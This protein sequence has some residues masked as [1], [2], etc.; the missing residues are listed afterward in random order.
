MQCIR[1]IRLA[2]KSWP[3]SRN[4]TT[5]FYGATIILQDKVNYSWQSSASDQPAAESVPD[6]SLLAFN[7]KTVNKLPS[8]HQNCWIAGCRESVPLSGIGHSHLEQHRDWMVEESQN[9]SSVNLAV[10]GLAL[11]FWN[12]AWPQ[13]TRAGYSSFSL[14]YMWSSC[15]QY[16]LALMVQLCETSSKCSTSWK[17]HQR[18][19]F[20]VFFPLPKW[21]RAF[22]LT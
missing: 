10:C 19:R 6:I 16:S 21:V 7:Q 15:C 1:N 9:L 8:P 14:L 13:L 4:K 17:F 20:V 3:G 22:W 18:L 2:R 12:K 11:S 5:K